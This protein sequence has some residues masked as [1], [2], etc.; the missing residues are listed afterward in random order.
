MILDKMIPAIPAWCRRR[1]HIEPDT[2]IVPRDVEACAWLDE[3]LPRA[4]ILRLAVRADTACVRN[5]PFR[6]RVR[7]PG[8]AGRDRSWAFTRQRQAAMLRKHRHHLR[9]RL[10]A[11]CNTGAG[12][13]GHRHRHAGQN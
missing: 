10:P 7:R 11:S 4:W 2:P 6:R 5:E 3:E 9:A 12:L 1:K 13:P 8:D